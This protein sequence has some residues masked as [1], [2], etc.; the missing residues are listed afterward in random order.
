MNKLLR[1]LMQE[2][3][4]EPAGA[5]APEMVPDAMEQE[6]KPAEPT[7][8]TKALEAAV[9]SK[10]KLEA[11]LAEANTKLEA[12]GADTASLAGIRKAVEEKDYDKLLE[13]GVDADA[14][15]EFVVN[16]GDG[17]TPADQLQ[18]RVDELEKKLGDKEKAEEQAKAEAANQK[19]LD[20]CAAFVKD[21]EGYEFTH[22]LG[23]SGNI[24]QAHLQAASK[25]EKFNPVEYAAQHEKDTREVVK[26]NLTALKDNKDFV[27]M[28][29]ELGFRKLGK[30]P[31]GDESEEDAHTAAIQLLDMPRREEQQR[32]TPRKNEETEDEAHEAALIEFRKAQSGAS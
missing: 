1:I 22:L 3:T 19:N 7:D 21:N 27:E 20:T 11:Q 18:A 23:L 9:E 13:L 15:L 8:P 6:S 32:F 29:S 24:N 16:K 17:P 12:A 26:K 5:P 4:G 30:D 2:T 14:F 28:M 25:K 10:T 31:S